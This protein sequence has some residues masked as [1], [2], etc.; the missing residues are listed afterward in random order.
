MAGS[1]SRS[2]SPSRK[3]ASSGGGGQVSPKFATTAIGAWWMFIGMLGLVL[4]EKLLAMYEVP[5]DALK[6]EGT[7][8]TLVTLTMQ[9]WMAW[10]MMGVGML[11][12]TRR[13]G[14]TRTTGLICLSSAIGMALFLATME[15]HSGGNGVAA[16]AGTA[17]TGWLG[18]GMPMKAVY[19]NYA[20]FGGLVG[21][22]VMGWIDAGKPEP[23]L[24]LLSAPGNFSPGR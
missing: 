21:L 18:L 13:E 2:K 15:L 4:P 8:Y 5:L 3:A 12:I 24:S 17:G 7:G 11:S 1:A 9:F 6:A 19:A 23:D 22:N 14:D 20:V 10:M 16:T